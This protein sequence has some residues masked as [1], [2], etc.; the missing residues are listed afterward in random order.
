MKL[1][2]FPVLGLSLVEIMM[3]SGTSSLVI[4]SLLSASVG[5]Q[6]SF[7]AIESFSR[8]HEVQMRL[9]DY[10][11]QDLRRATK[12]STYS[13]VT[14]LTTKLTSPPTVGF[15]TVTEQKYLVLTLPGFYASENEESALYRKINPLIAVGPGNGA[16]WG[17][18]YGLSGTAIA[19]ESIVRYEQVINADGTK[20]YLR[21][22]G[23]AAEMAAGTAQAQVIADNAE[24]IYLNVT[25]DTPLSFLI[26]MWFEIQRGTG[27]VDIKSSDQVMIRNPRED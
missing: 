27:K 22:Q 2:K 11:A 3:A 19:P 18:E 5:L 1:S 8:G 21:R 15:M 20:S 6:K 14:G 9:I 25:A 16:V 23:S 7:H 24:D 4:S 17:I 26:E 10:V 13:P 12:I